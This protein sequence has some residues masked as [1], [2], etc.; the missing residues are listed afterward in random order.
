[1]LNHSEYTNVY[2]ALS[3]FVFSFATNDV[4]KGTDLLN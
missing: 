4:D 3:C 1:M 2:G